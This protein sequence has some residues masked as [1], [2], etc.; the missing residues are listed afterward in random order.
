MLKPSLAIVALFFAVA[1]QSPAPVIRVE[2]DVKPG[3][4]PTTMEPKRE[5]MV[6]IAILT[7]S[8]FDATT[9]DPET[10]HA[11]ATGTEA[12]IFR[13]MVED[14]DRDRDTDMLLLFR[15]QQMRLACDGTAIV[16]KGK[17]QSGQAIEGREAVTM[18]GCQ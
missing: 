9:V 6:P 15:V 17:T 3:D 5:G 7:T 1:A 16:L 8:T 4:Q 11:G 13:S 18:G 14:V 2:I 12:A 10:V